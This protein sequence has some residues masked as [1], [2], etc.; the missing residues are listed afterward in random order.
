ME[1]VQNPPP[2]GEPENIT[3]ERVEVGADG[4]GCPITGEMI[5]VDGELRGDVE[6][7]ER[8][9]HRP[10]CWAAAAAN[11][12]LVHYD[13]D[14]LDAVTACG[15]NLEHLPSRKSFTPNPA[16]VTCPE[17][18]TTLVDEQLTDQAPPEPTRRTVGL[19]VVTDQLRADDASWRYVSG[20]D[21]LTNLP[22]PDDARVALVCRD[23]GRLIGIPETD[24]TWGNRGRGPADMLSILLRQG[25]Q[26]ADGLH[27]DA[28][29]A[30]LMPTPDVLAVLSGVSATFWTK[31]VNMSVVGIQ[32][33]WQLVGDLDGVQTFETVL[34]REYCSGSDGCTGGEDCIIL[35]VHD[36]R[37]L[38]QPGTLIVPALS[39]QRVHLLGWLRPQVRI[40]ADQAVTR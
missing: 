32:P 10:G 24:V 35:V 20:V 25:R 6:G 31:P 15:L 3:R 14:H 23:H 19:E 12:P 22:L 40:P 1:T 2:E 4:C 16:H 39:G 18:T 34:R 17:C 5:A 8:V 7:T 38:A 13:L 33:G 26:L 27:G 36:G 28:G 37:A 30:L 9:E 21:A 29:G 11:A